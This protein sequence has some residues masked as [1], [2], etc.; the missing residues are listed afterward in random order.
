MRRAFAEDRFKKIRGYYGEKYTEYLAAL[1]VKASWS[2]SD[3]PELIGKASKD[4]Q[5][6]QTNAT[7][8]G[9]ASGGG[10]ENYVGD[11]AGQ[12]QGGHATRIRP[13]FC[14]EHGLIMMIGV[15]RMET[16]NDFGNC[17]PWL[18][19]DR[20]ER[21]YTPPLDNQLLQTYDSALWPAD[22][23]GQIPQG[24]RFMEYRKP[25]N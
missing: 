15:A 9:I 3:E 24:Q 19:K 17:P 14:P 16:V 25:S 7:V 4:W 12:F 5:F 13:T 11:P 1:G 23:L 18:G 20:W 10:E 6:S 22:L 21:Y 2:I 8:N